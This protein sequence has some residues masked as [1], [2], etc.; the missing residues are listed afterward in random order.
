M[1]RSGYLSKIKYFGLI[2]ALL[3]LLFIAGC[4]FATAPTA[5]PVSITFGY[6]DFDKAFYEL[7]VQQFQASHPEITIELKQR[8]ER[9]FRN[10]LDEFD[11]VVVT[12]AEVA[13]LREQGQIVSF[14][15][16]LQQD[17]TF[18]AAD[19]YPASWGLFTS[20]GQRWAIPSGLDITV[21]FYNQD[22][23]DRYSVAY[24]QP[25]WTWDDFLKTAQALQHEDAGVFGY[26]PLSYDRDRG[27]TDVLHFIYQHN[28]RIFDDLEHPTQTTFDDPLTIEAVAWYNALIN[29]YNVAPTPEQL[30]KWG[31]GRYATYQ[32]ILSNKAGMWMGNFS[33]RGGNFFWP[34]TWNMHWG[35]APLPRDAQFVA[36]ASANG[37]V[38]LSQIEN[39][40][41]CWEWLKFLSQQ[42]PE[43]DIPARK[44]LLESSAYQK[45][46]GE[47]TAQVIQ[48]TLENAVIPSLETD[49]FRDAMAVFSKAI[50]DV[51]NQRATPADALIRAQRDA[52]AKMPQ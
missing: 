34:V 2:G 38:V 11:V 13:N 1:R 49:K 12:P 39:P 7:A 29:D 31:L 51:L 36:Q 28:G 3:P 20:E 43:R 30:R 18:N 6:P 40:Q 32:G 17:A 19:F 9:L 16:F 15:P 44:S 5:E 22:L 37:Y 23:F 24:P 42:L 52:M 10:D 25:G 26:A 50:D 8:F 45:K 47:N 27:L 35:I 14:E 41:A 4:G 46:V 33:E 21:M 48:V